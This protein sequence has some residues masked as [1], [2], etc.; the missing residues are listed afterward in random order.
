[1]HLHIHEDAFFQMTCEVRVVAT[2][3]TTALWD[4]NAQPSVIPE[5]GASTRRTQR[6]HGVLI[7]VHMTGSIKTFSWSQ[8]VRGCVDITVVLTLPSM[9]VQFVSMYLLGL[10]SEVYRHTA[11]TKLN[12]V[13][14]FHNTIAKL[15]L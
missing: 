4:N 1:M 9:I 3:V 7:D 13:A 14:K 6:V 2:P 5:I 15:M 11:R 10:V 8:L 12:I